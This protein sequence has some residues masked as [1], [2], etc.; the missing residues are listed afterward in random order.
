M[1]LSVQSYHGNQFI[2]EVAE[3]LRSDEENMNSMFESDGFIAFNLTYGKVICSSLNSG[4]T[5]CIAELSE[6]A[7]QI[8]FE[9]N[10]NDKDIPYK[11]GFCDKGS[12]R[13]EYHS[14]NFS[15]TIV[16]GSN[17]I[18]TP[19]NN[20]RLITPVSKRIRFLYVFISPQFLQEYFNIEKKELKISISNKPTGEFLFRK[21]INSPQINL[22]LSELF[23]QNIHDN[24]FKLFLESKSLELLSLFLEQFITTRSNFSNKEKD[25]ILEMYQLIS[26]DLSKTFTVKELINLSGLNEHKLQGGFKTLFGTTVQKLIKRLRLQEARKLILA[27]N[28]T[29]S[30][31]GYKVGYTNMS[32]FATAFRQEFG[33]FPKELK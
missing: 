26:D 21:G 8:E 16:E 24:L 29:V 18:I 31:A 13:V 4:L 19:R 9:F 22:I 33:I 30:E 32:H 6:N 28:N 5:I 7:P 23:N 11:I 3:Y 27:E 17:L 10:G 25:K 2:S 12:Y 20:S 14:E 15:E 1:K